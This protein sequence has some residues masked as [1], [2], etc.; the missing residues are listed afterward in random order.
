[1]HPMPSPP[2]CRRALAAV[3]LSVCAAVPAVAQTTAP[4]VFFLFDTSGSMNY[5]PP[6]TQSQLDAGACA[7]L[8]PTGDCFVPM[9]G[10]DPASKMYQ[11]KQGLHSSIAQRDDL[12][13]GFASLNQDAL[14]V[15]AKH[16]LYQATNS[17]PVLSSTLGAFPAAGAQEVFGLAWSCGSGSGDGGVGC[18]ST[19]PA[20]LTDPWELTRVRRLSKGGLSFTQTLDFYIR[21]GGSTYKAHYVPTGTAVPG[22]SVI[23]T[24]VTV[25]K[26][27]NSTCSTSLPVAPGTIT[28]SW[29]LVS[30]F[31]S[32]DLGVLRTDPEAGYFSQTS[33]ADASTSNTCAGWEP[34]TD[35][36]SDKNSSG[37][38][39]RWPTDSSDVRGSAFYVGDV[40]PLDW[41]NDHKLDVEKRLAPNLALNSL[42]TP[43][44]RIATYLKDIPV[45]P[46]SF[47]R[48]KDESAR[49]LIAFGSTPLGAS[50]GSFNTWYGRW[51]S[52]AA[53]RDPDWANR[54]TALVLLTDGGGEICGGDPC[55]QAGTLYTQYGIRTFVVELGGQPV[56]GGALECAAASGGTTAPYYPQ[57]QQELTDDLTAIYAAAA[58]P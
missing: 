23:K 43:D 27:T 6:C 15:R 36:T 40:I 35:T 41:N 45:S 2:R 14:Y 10:D 20:D 29:S 50:L 13:L 39:L 11:L 54:H 34:N 22:A 25:Y 19:N 44:F 1:M 33:A 52:V 26:C 48:L 3:L 5:S 53:L 37:Y 56:A 24:A 58:N 51:Q 8:C 21:G 12:L 16:W 38:D 9:Q 28:I 7:Y 42:A 55:G 46:D 32:W 49:P 17:G 18:T 31:V 47:L 4:Y 30:D 57:T